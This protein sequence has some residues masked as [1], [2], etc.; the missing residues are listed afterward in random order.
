MGRSALAAAEDCSRVDEAASD[1]AGNDFDA[2]VICDAVHCD[3][4][5]VGKARLQCAV[6]QQNAIRVATDRA[7]VY[8]L[9]LKDAGVDDDADARDVRATRDVIDD[10]AGIVQEAVHTADRVD[11]NQGAIFND[12]EL[13]V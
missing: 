5:G 11:A 3:E 6:K 7:Q 8:E 1:V 13:G 12:D 4:T 2:V 10:D 9:A